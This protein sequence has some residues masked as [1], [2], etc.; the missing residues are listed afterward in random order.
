MIAILHTW[1]QTLSLHPH[2]NYTVPG[3]GLTKH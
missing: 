2:L 1:E 3:G